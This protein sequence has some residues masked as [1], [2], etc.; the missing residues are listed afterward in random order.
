[1]VELFL[2]PTHPGFYV[3]NFADP[4]LAQTK[5]AGIQAYAYWALGIAEDVNAS[6]DFATEK[7][8]AI[9]CLTDMLYDD[10]HGGFYFFTMRNGSLSIPWYFFEIYPNDGKRLDHLALGATALFDAWVETGNST[11]LNIAKHAMDFL[12]VEMQE[13]YG[14]DMTG[15]R[16]AVQRNGG[17]LTL[18]PGLRPGDT[19]VTDLNAIAIRALLRGYNTTG[20]S[21]YLDF[22]WDVFTALLEYSWDSALGGW[23]TETLDGL[24]YDPLDDEDVKYFKVSEIQLQMI[25][26]LEDLYEVSLDQF[27]LRMAIDTFDLVLGNLWEP[28]DEGF[29]RNGNQEWDVLDFDWEVHFTTVQCQAIISLNTMWAYGL[30]YVSNVRIQPIS[31]RPQDTID[32]IATAQDADGIDIVYVNY[33]LSVNGTETNDILLLPE[34]PLAGGVYNNSIPA[35]ANNTRCNFI[36]VAND[37]TGREFI[38]GSYFFIVST[39]NF[40]PVITLRAIYPTDEVR[41]G[42][43]VV[44]DLEVYEYPLHSFVWT[45]ELWW[46]VNSGAFS[47]VNMTLLGADG[48]HLVYRHNLGQFHAGDSLEFEGHIEDEAGNIGISQR[49]R[50]TILGPR[51]AVTPLAAWQVI[52]TVG[53]IAAPG[54]GYMWARGRSRGYSE[55]Q[56]Q[57]KKEAKRRAR[58]RGPRRRR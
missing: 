33:T 49:F 26:T 45:C 31:P 35:L 11:L 4:D 7:D 48:D 44:I 24:P 56:K 19:V 1:M 55:A 36:V 6:L 54:I 40:A 28:I 9:R 43:D 5:R 58:R 13:W 8:S 10:V 30:P 50:L 38:A 21:T 52:A 17:T 29:V 41:V 37:T 46:R 22:A 47:S 14:M 27:P 12:Y 53:L 25:L 3:N 18:D 16:L 15:L 2:D 23:F 34:N 57:G 51:Q 39:D 32:F 42:D 20:N